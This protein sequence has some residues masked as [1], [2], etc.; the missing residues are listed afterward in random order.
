MD[1][2]L[3]DFRETQKLFQSDMAALLQINQSNVSRMEL[4]GVCYLTLPQY[5]TLC[6][7]FGD[8]AVNAFI[9]KEGEQQVV[10]ANNKNE[11]SGTQDNSVTMND[12]TAM[13]VIQTQA[14]AL[15]E[16]LKKQAEQSDRML[17]LLEKLTEKLS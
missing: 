6:E 7:K 16:S 12:A 5:K 17:T 10:V 1:F 15:S 13:L 8:E 9:V 4:K 11:G 2:R 3:K 14:K